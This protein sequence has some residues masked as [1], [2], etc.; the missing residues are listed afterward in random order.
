MAYYYKQNLLTV[1]TVFT[2]HVPC[3]IRRVINFGAK[4][5]LSIKTD[6]RVDRSWRHCRDGLLPTTYLPT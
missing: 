5:C 3:S 6:P 2:V 4:M 1:V